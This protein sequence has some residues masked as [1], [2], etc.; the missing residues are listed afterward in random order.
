MADNESAT[1]S[2]AAAE[3]DEVSLLKI[4]EYLNSAP[5]NALSTSA[6]RGLA[7]HLNNRRLVMTREGLATDWEGLAQLC[8]FEIL[9]IGNLR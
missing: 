8:G 7:M 2:P 9:Y 3:E 6:H 1:H 4:P 5:V